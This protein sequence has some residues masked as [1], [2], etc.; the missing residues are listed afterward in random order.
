MKCCLGLL[1]VFLLFANICLFAI[2]PE[3]FKSNVL[4]IDISCRESFFHGS[5]VLVIQ[6]VSNV[7]LNLWLRAKGKIADVLI[8]GGQTKEF[9]WAQGFKFDANNHFFIGSSGFDTIHKTMPAKEL[10]PYRVG[11]ADGGIA[12]SFS[13]EFLQMQLAKSEKLPLKKTNKFLTI[14]LQR[15]PNIIL[16]ENSDKIYADIT[17][18]TSF[19][20]NKLTIPIDVA[21][22]FV[23]IYKC[24]SGQVWASQINLENIDMNGVPE[25]MMYN[26]KQAVN[27]IV[28]ELYSDYI[29]YQIEKKWLINLTK[30]LNL[31]TKVV[32]GRLE[33]IVL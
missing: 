10:S 27:L 11:L 22:S 4:P 17:F 14:E 9:G 3:S 20:S 19:F 26:I 18:Q 23:P 21:I 30:V 33:L 24:T 12:L 7:D 32:D 5:Y 8:R 1:Y 13:K 25:D 28:Q 15:T 2:E 16:K 6:N 31:R 29:I